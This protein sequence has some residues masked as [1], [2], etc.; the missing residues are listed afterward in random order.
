MR[1]IQILKFA[2]I[3]VLLLS[4]LIG[5]CGAQTIRDI[6]PDK[7]VKIFDFECSFPSE[8][9][10]DRSILGLTKEQQKAMKKVR[11]KILK[12]L[13]DADDLQMQLGADN[14]KGP[15]LPDFNRMTWEELMPMLDEAQLVKFTQFNL[16]RY[17]QN[18]SKSEWSRYSVADAP[19]QEFI[20]CAPFANWLGVSKEQ[21]RALQNAK[22]EAEEAFKDFESKYV[23]INPKES[24]EAKLLAQWQTALYELLLPHQQKVYNDAIGEPA[25]FLNRFFDKFFVEPR[26]FLFDPV[27]LSEIE[28]TLT[29]EGKQFELGQLLNLTHP[30]LDAKIHPHALFDFLLDGNV[31]KDLKINGLQMEQLSRLRDEWFD[32]NP[33][34]DKKITVDI[35]KGRKMTTRAMRVAAEEFKQKY[36][37]YHDQVDRI[38][39]PKQQERLRQL[40][41]QFLMSRGW[42]EVPLTCPEWVEYLELTQT[43]RAEF[44]RVNE[45]FCY[46]HERI[47]WEMEEMLRDI[48]RNL[49]DKI[50]RI[51]TAKQKET[52]LQFIAIRG[53]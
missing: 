29:R 26:F 50:S 17:I 20:F 11:G 16:V 51:L 19:L 45:K 34:P 38:L 43:Q 41:N 52:I 44:N 2:A 33:R 5:T 53:Y 46:R 49:E 27:D 22:R 10:N 6:F 21:Q 35:E 13:S 7:E 4:F 32:E 15:K 40:G 31:S 47:E 42:L 24:M 48:N 8:T 23:D 14:Y 18:L 36:G 37:R 25:S 39:S 28:S 12:A 1:R 9:L 3:P 30:H